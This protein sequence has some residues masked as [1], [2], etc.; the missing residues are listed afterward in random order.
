MNKVKLALASLGAVF[1]ATWAAAVLA[2]PAQVMATVHLRAGPATEYPAFAVLGPGTPLEV[3]GCEEHFDWCDVQAGP[4]RGWVDAAYLQMSSGGQSLIVADSGVVLALPVVTFVLDTYWGS[5]YRGRPWYSNRA[6][7]YPYYRRYPHGRPPPRPRPPVVRPPPR[8][9]PGIR[10]PR[11]Q[12]PAGTR[13]PGG[14]RPTPG[15]SRP[16]NGGRPPN[17]GRPDS[18]NQRPSP[19]PAPQPT[20]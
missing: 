3:Y 10:P 2:A 1:L 13:P 17:T 4:N 9:S 12:P 20:Q 18:G 7:Y 15:G 16:P 19:R 6:R 8:P 11:P 14:N 5:Y